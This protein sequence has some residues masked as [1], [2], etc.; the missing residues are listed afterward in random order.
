M[1]ELNLDECGIR[2][3]EVESW[4]EEGDVESEDSVSRGPLQSASDICD[5]EVLYGHLLDATDPEDAMIEAIQVRHRWFDNSDMNHARTAGAEPDAL[6]EEDRFLVRETLDRIAME[7]AALGKL[8]S[9][10]KVPRSHLME[11]ERAK[12]R[13]GSNRHNG[14]RKPP[15][16]SNYRRAVPAL[17]MTPPPAQKVLLDAEEERYFALAD[18]I[19]R[20][21]HEE[22]RETMR[23]Q[24]HLL[25]LVAVAA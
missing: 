3:C 2:P 6:T 18:E 17:V 14:G 16:P 25:A 19:T 22:E 15:R 20:V 9:T 12:R 1:E 8:S 11:D 13:D 10:T 7:T 4:M 23:M 21:V 5:Q 24:M